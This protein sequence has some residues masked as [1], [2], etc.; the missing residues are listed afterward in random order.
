MEFHSEKPKTIY[1][2]VKTQNA[3]IPSVYLCLPF[4]QIKRRNKKKVQLVPR[5]T[6][7]VVKPF[8]LLSRLN[9]NHLYHTHLG[10]EMNLTLMWCL[11]RYRQC[12]PPWIP[13]RPFRFQIY[14]DCICTSKRND[15]I[16]KIP[17]RF[18]IVLARPLSLF[19]KNVIKKEFG[20]VWPHDTRLTHRPGL[21]NIT[22]H[23]HL[24][25][26]QQPDRK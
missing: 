7:C 11:A 1:S 10:N 13:F 12:I 5:P 22:F 19:W 21:H 15:T 6:R 24:I 4:Q 25:I 17:I 2:N 18:L 9:R 3:A 14:M 26:E 23:L 16:L 20:P 8:C